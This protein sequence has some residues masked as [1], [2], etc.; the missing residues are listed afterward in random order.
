LVGQIQKA[1]GYLNAKNLYIISIFLFGDRMSDEQISGPEP[2]QEIKPVRAKRI[3]KRIVKDGSIA[4]PKQVSIE[5][6]LSIVLVFSI[7][8]NGYLVMQTQ[9][10]GGQITT[11]T[12]TVDKLSS[13]AVRSNSTSS[14][15]P[16][17]ITIINDKRC[18][19]CDVS[20]LMQKLQQVFPMAVFTQLDYSEAKG[21]Y[22]ASNLSVLP[23]VLFDES[24]ASSANFQQVAG[25]LAPAGDYMS[26]ALGSSFDPICDGDKNCALE[27]CKSSAGCR[28]NIP[29][30][31]DLFVMS[32]CPYGTQA[33]NAMKDVLG[34]IKDINFKIHYIGGVNPQTGELESLHGPAEVV[35][36]MRQI[37]AAKYYPSKYLDYIWCRNKNIASVEWQSCALLSNMSVD[38]IGACASGSEGKALLT[39][40][41]AVADSMAVGAS[42][43]WLANNKVIFS[44]LAPEEIKS[45]Y[46]EQNPNIY[47]CNVSLSTA[48]NISGSCAV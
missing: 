48:T 14:D 44:A 4:L 38:T 10:M 22:T 18:T 6:L 19:T 2:V 30:K 24:V 16:V 41:F 36:D 35:E 15:A 37:C 28:V 33:V 25:Y 43:T 7:V 21:I 8:C 20:G 42:P 26:L 23:A 31:L 34:V 13:N 17:A 1:L 11:L 47:G 32:Q 45:G 5:K 29:G 27:R 46:C 39:A 12:S 40:D 9:N 3:S